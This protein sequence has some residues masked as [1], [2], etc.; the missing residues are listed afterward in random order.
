MRRSRRRKLE[1]CGRVGGSRLRVLAS[2]AE[3]EK[4]GSERRVQ[5]SAIAASEAALAKAQ[6]N[7]RLDE[8]VRRAALM[9]RALS[10][11]IGGAGLPAFGGPT[12]AVPWRLEQGEF[13]ERQEILRADDGNYSLIESSEAAIPGALFVAETPAAAPAGASWWSF[14]RCRRR[15]DA[16]RVRR[17]TKTSEAGDGGR[18]K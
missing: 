7:E 15:A 3:S 5:Q 8:R 18:P 13:F 2:D 17:R 11:S 1:R 4:C 10:E 16:V 9:V 12:A 6:E 14:F